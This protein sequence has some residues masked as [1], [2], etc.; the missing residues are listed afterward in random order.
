[1]S[2]QN[3]L[4]RSFSTWRRKP[5]YG[6]PA[7][8]YFCRLVGEE[9]FQSAEV[10]GNSIGITMKQAH[11]P[12]LT[13][14]V[15][16]LP[17]PEQAKQSMEHWTP[18]RSGNF[19]V[20]AGQRLR[21]TQIST[22]RRR[23]CRGC[24]H[25]RDSHRVWWDV[26]QFRTCPIHG[27]PLEDTF[28]G[29]RPL[30]WW[31]PQFT[32]APN[33]ESLV[34]AWQ[35]V[36]CRDL[37][38]HYLL[39]RLGCTSDRPRPLLDDVE[40]YQVIDLCGLLGRFFDTPWSQRAP[41]FDIS[42]QTGFE[43]LSGT[44]QDLV[45]KFESW[46]VSNAENALKSGIES[47]LGWIRKGGRGVNILHKTWKR[48]DLA[49]KEAFAR[50]GRVT[51]F[52]ELKDFDFRYIT[53]QALQ[54]ELG[55]SY[56]KAR[57]FL[58]LRGLEPADLKYSRED[59]EKIRA[60][61]DRLLTHKD[62]AALLGCSKK[63]IRFLVM[64]GH[65]V[66]Y[67]GMTR[68]SEFKVEPESIVALANKITSLPLH[69]QKGTR[70]TLWNYAR[71]NGISH[72]KL[73]TMLLSGEV[74]PVAIRKDRPGFS[75]LRMANAPTSAA[76]R[77][78]AKEGEMTFGRARALLGLR[79]QSVA[80]LAHAG[81]LRIARSSGKSHFLSVDTVNAFADRYVEA[82]KY[83]K[84]LRAERNRI[85]ERLEV[86]GVSRH[87]TEIEGMHD[88]IVEKRVLLKALG[89]EDV[90]DAV[91]DKWR[92]FSSYV[93]SNCPAFLLPADVTRYEQTIFNSTRVARFTASAVGDRIVL[94]K[95]FN[96]RANREWRWF[97][98][99]EGEVLKLMEA[100]DFKKVP[101][102]N[103]VIGA[104]YLD[105]EEVMASLTKALGDYHWL[106]LKT[107]I[108]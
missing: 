29:N 15:F 62:C 33:G 96:P 63:M 13:E 8:A 107:D 49:Q 99:H 24:L 7:Y 78:T 52:R 11:S 6:E 18:R 43:A 91:Q 90:S 77:S 73:V 37:F 50:V 67:L 100:F 105:D 57:A 21:T 46:L 31:W 93:A 40:V 39:Q 65:L 28:G 1:M 74:R 17:L 19:Y 59:V 76:V 26:V 108:R 34:A 4:S 10:Y 103:L 47:G 5:A 86:L 94:R 22:S 48:I 61:I 82:S 101:S 60:E 3:R 12:R 95:K 88:H 27:R 32:Y 68:T 85:A 80:P 41:K 58:R 81:V 54:K 66:G 71:W 2:V 16:S 98:E 36:D 104:C 53:S 70:L 84:E 42:Y 56:K 9:G 69:E 106:L 64:T 45:E 89:I 38:E 51:Q 44:H 35:P 87:F 20:V 83:R 14:K 55:I 30:L 72:R 97:R 92:L 25:E 23:F 79:H 75:A 102:K